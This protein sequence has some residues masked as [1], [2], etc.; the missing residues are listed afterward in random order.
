MDEN[1]DDLLRRLQDARVNDGENPSSAPVDSVPSSI[2]RGLAYGLFPENDQ[3][4]AVGVYRLLG[5]IG[6]G[7]MG[8]VYLAEQQVPVRR[9]VALKIIKPLHKTESN[10]AQF[11]NE[12]IALCHLRHGNI[13]SLLDAGTTE[14]GY[15]F[16]VLE[17]IDG[18]SITQYCDRHRLTIDQ[19]LGLFFQ[20]AD[21][22]Q[23]MHDRGIVHRDLK[24]GN[25]LVREENG[26]P[27]V[28]IVDLGLAVGIGPPIEGGIESVEQCRVGGTPSYMSPEQVQG[29]GYVVGPRTDIFALGVMLYELLVGQLPL[30]LPTRN[31]LANVQESA[32]YWSRVQ[33]IIRDEQPPLASRR[34][35]ENRPTADSTRLGQRKDESS[36]GVSSQK[37]RE[38]RAKCRHTTVRKLQRMVA[39]DLELI[40]DKAMNKQPMGRYAS[41]DELANDIRRHIAYENVTA[42]IPRRPFD[43]Y[44]VRKW[45]HRHS[46]IAFTAPLAVATLLWFAVS[47]KLHTKAL[48]Q[49][50]TQ[51][52]AALSDAE[53]RLYSAAGRTLEF[54]LLSA[55][56]GSKRQAVRVIDQSIAL[57]DELVAKH[58]DNAQYKLDR[59][60]AARNLGALRGELG[61]IEPARALLDSCMAILRDVATSA[62][63]FQ[64]A[65]VELANAHSAWGRIQHRLGKF[66]DAETEYR[67]AEGIRVDLLKT[68]P[69][70]IEIVIGR[71]RSH[72]EIG[73]LLRDSKGPDAKAIHR[74]E[75]AKAL[76]T[77][78]SDALKQL[79]DVQE[80]LLVADTNLGLLYDKNNRSDDAKKLYIDTVTR[81]Q[82]AVAADPNGNRSRRF[83]AGAL[84]NLG[85]YFAERDNFV[86]GVQYLT[87]A[88]NEYGQV[89]RDEDAT[90]L[91]KSLY[92]K[93]LVN[94]AWS[95]FRSLRGEPNRAVAETVRIACRKA[96][97]EL[98]YLMLVMPTNQDLKVSAVKANNTLAS[99]AFEAKDPEVA[100]RHYEEALSLLKGI[101]SPILDVRKQFLSIANNFARLEMDWPSNAKLN[102][103]ETNTRGI[104]WAT[105]TIDDAIEFGESLMKENPGNSTIL[106]ETSALYDARGLLKKRKAEHLAATPGQEAAMG[107]LF[108]QAD[109][110]Y[111]R[112]IQL[113]ERAVAL[114]H[115]VAE[116]KRVLYEIYARRGNLR[117]ILGMPKEAAKDWGAALQSYDR[118]HPRWPMLRVGQGHA[119]LMAGDYRAGLQ[120][121]EEVEKAGPRGHECR[122]NMACIF[123]L[124][125]RECEIDPKLKPKEKE[126]V[127]R[128]YFER[129]I[130]W[131]ESAR[132]NGDFKNKDVRQAIDT[133][134]ELR[135]LRDDERFQ[136]FVRSLPPVT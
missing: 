18:P 36:D 35:A 99:L 1:I 77:Q 69:D 42:R 102:A 63:Y 34:L 59:A 96:L 43:W 78:W 118:T 4:K 129:A 132:D 16:L 67:A 104:E 114:G 7:G 83:F 131:L 135:I 90:A 81:W 29:A 31:L 123:A 130:K 46:T 108:T 101:A 119:D 95:Q 2:L 64:R 17:L 75:E 107:S 65:Q 82:L 56:R 6:R 20:L 85:I 26:K 110:A 24:P 79:P 126:K 30:L 41:A 92:A 74:Y 40:A 28:K 97:D 23:H 127:K 37:S 68:M 73:D 128:E 80:V 3:R 32:A 50:K 116:D 21:A 9:R 88:V 39:E 86:D 124:A 91:T 62:D 106:M 125:I 117:E 93:A 103:G 8:E 122:Y 71:I 70:E 57:Y 105:Q 58:P 49:Q 100:R 52:V 111:S 60:F 115:P 136:I 133:D 113:G 48:E 15:P 89:L 14:D 13:A 45:S 55:Q 84:A 27:L 76:S 44:R 51:L 120:A 87:Q 25:V 19:R 54:G 12:V 72:L 33:A 66:T 38:D 22:V 47:E 53:S 61:Q 112:G 10:D 98:G 11:H 109:A 94:L 134:P 121:V 5:W